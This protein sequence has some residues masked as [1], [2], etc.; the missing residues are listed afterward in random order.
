[1]R[2]GVPV[3]YLWANINHVQLKRECD[4]I[5]GRAK[6]M[7]ESGREIPLVC[8]CTGTLGACPCEVELKRERERH[9]CHAN[10]VDGRV[11]QEGN[12]EQDMASLYRSSTTK[13][14]KPL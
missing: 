10:E 7:H 13:C 3:R 2:V 12:A 14:V 1:M 6:G 8:L 5:P 11:K 4:A 9:P